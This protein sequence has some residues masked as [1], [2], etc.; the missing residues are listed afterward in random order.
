MAYRSGQL[1]MLKVEYVYRSGSR[2]HLGKGT[3]IKCRFRLTDTVHSFLDH[4]RHS[5]IGLQSTSSNGKELYLVK[6][7]EHTR[8]DTHKHATLESYG[9]EN[10]DYMYLQ[11]YKPL[12]RIK[13]P[14]EVTGPD[15]QKLSIDVLNTTTIQ[16]L[17]HKIQNE[18]GIHESEFLLYHKSR[19]VSSSSKTIE[20]YSGKH[21]SK[22]W[23]RVRRQTLKS[24]DER[25][26]RSDTLGCCLGNTSSYGRYRFKFIIVI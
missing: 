17:R 26:L 6:K 14:I 5:F 8:L 10:G 1:A 21:S 22:E 7:G 11:G 19:K 9:V 20:F 25:G 15:G 13:F 23:L 2:L 12:S 24:H 18:T 3:T 16:S 4:L